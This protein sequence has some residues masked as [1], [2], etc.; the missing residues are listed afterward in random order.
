MVIRV[1]LIALL[2]LLGAEFVYF[3]GKI[4]WLGT[5]SFFGLDSSKSK[6]TSKKESAQ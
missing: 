4:V 3:I 6:K 5:K 1:L 2:L